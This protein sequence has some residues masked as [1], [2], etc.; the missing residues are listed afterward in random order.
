MIPYIGD[1]SKQDA[2]ILKF[3]SSNA[4]CILEAGVGGSTQVISAYS[5]GDF[6]AIETNISWIEKTRK[7]ID[8]LGID[9]QVE[10]VLY[11]EFMKREP[12]QRYDMIFVDLVDDLRKDFGCYSF[13]K[14][15][16]IGGFQLWHDQRRTSDI[17]NMCEVIRGYSAYIE[18]VHINYLESNITVIRKRLSPLFYYNWNL[19]AFEDRPEWLQGNEDVPQNEIKNLK[20][21][22]LLEL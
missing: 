10:F 14:L 6:T 21:K 9:K 3:Y 12:E 19:P 16:K 13:D 15:L 1:I 7:N 5:K 18:S 4:N 8:L 11:D 2:E 20:R 17:H 22:T